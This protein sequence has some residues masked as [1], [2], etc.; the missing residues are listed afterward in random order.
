MADDIRVTF[1]AES[2]SYQS[3]LKKLIAQNKL[4]ETELKNLGSTFKEETSEEE[5]S[6][7]KK[8]ALNKQIKAQQEYVNALNAGMDKLTAEQKENTAEGLKQS[9]AISKAE[10]ALADMK[11]ELAEADK[12]TEE[13][14]EEVKD[15]G[16]NLEGFS[17]AAVM[18][19]SRELADFFN[20]AAG[21][22][23]EF[24]KK[25]LGGIIDTTKDFDSAM[26]QVSA[27]SGATGEEFDALRN[28]ARE[29]GASTKYSATESAEALNYMALAGWDTAEMTEGLDGVLNLA[30]ASG[31]DLAEASDIVTDYL[32]AFGKDASYAAKMADMMAYA[33]ANSNTTTR[34]LGEAF[35]NS[36]ATMNT[37]GQT[38]E[39]TTA[40]LE[41]MANQGNKGAEA[42][43][44]LSAMMRDLTQKMKDGKIMIGD[45]AVQVTDASGNF[46]N[47]IDILADVDA[48]TEGMGSAQK[49]AALMTTFT[50]RSVKGV[51]QLLTEGVGNLQ[52]YETALQG[53]SGAAGDMANTMQD[54]LEGQLTILKSSVQE[55][56]ISMGDQLT[57]YIRKAVEIIQGIIDKFNQLPD[58][59]KKAIAITMAVGTAFAVVAP[60]VM[61]LVNT[62]KSLQA[63]SAVLKSFKQAAD[64]A[65]GSGG[66]MVSSFG[67]TAGVV[68]TAAAAIAAFN[69]A[70]VEA[71][72]AGNELYQAAK[73]DIEA[74]S[75]LRTES[76]AYADKLEDRRAKEEAEA[77]QIGKLADELVELNGKSKLTTEEQARYQSIVTQLNNLL[78][79][80][81][82]EIDNST[83]KLKDQSKASKEA[84]DEL[85][86]NKRALT[87]TEDLTE[88]QNDLSEA[89]MRQR[90]ADEIATRWAD[91]FGTSLED[92]KAKTE[93]ASVGA[94]GLAAKLAQISGNALYTELITIAQAVVDAG[95]GSTEMAADVAAATDEVNRL[96]G[97][98]AE[99]TPAVDE[100]GNAVD[101]LGDEATE[102]ATETEAAAV[103]IEDSYSEILT[104]AQKD[105]AGSVSYI[106]EWATEGGAS[107]EGMVNTMKT[108]AAA[109]GNYTK[110]IQTLTSDMRYGTDLNYTSM[111]D[112]LIQQGPKGANAVQQLA[113][114]M[115]TGGSN[116][117][118]AMLT[119]YNGVTVQG[120]NLVNS[121]SRVQADSRMKLGAM[122]GEA[123]SALTNYVNTI[124]SYTGKTYSAGSSVADN[125]YS[126]MNSRSG[127]FKGIGSGEV[128][129]L[130]TGIES[131]E[132]ATEDSAGVIADATAKMQVDSA[133][134]IN[135]G[136]DLVHNFA[137][138]MRQAAWDVSDAV[139]E[140]VKP[141]NNK[142]KHSVPKEGVLH[143]E[144]EWGGHLVDNFIKGMTSSRS[145]SALN[146]AANKVAFAAMPAMTMPSATTTNN[147]LT[148][149]DIVVNVNGAGVKDEAALA[150]MVSNE[151]FRRVQAQKAVWS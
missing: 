67:K 82:G 92:L 51:S 145:L 30:A 7:A 115:Q 52:S 141:I 93:N 99:A 89:V 5:K 109:Y 87:A 144:P 18:A 2:S 136:A 24:G 110:N 35:G 64:G 27:L 69:S 38:M 46:R 96:S 66:N 149:G 43:T 143:T 54:N 42:G 20:Q 94:G 21:A 151:I 81:S 130:N 73:K 123:N 138:G 32:S 126:G 39:T 48:A 113:N 97:A 118:N 129:N 76:E 101:I 108:N 142:L 37:A 150:K 50:A 116:M 55:L 107:V 59:A 148:Y 44:A 119:A 121:I 84:I 112:M 8:A 57:P 9:T 23:A 128:S 132:G 106:D 10:A 63:A 40:L 70:M 26:S 127:E 105:L 135:W 111:V 80:F 134:S 95:Q 36:A 75:E 1:N 16:V 4:Y 34:Q 124:S 100:A 56:A 120:G 125:A 78:P 33:Q 25:A 122:S 104:A 85:T 53:A 31:M 29:M 72:L 14:G 86:N 19:A 3:E 146:A 22:A 71:T 140:V 91:T 103:S 11:K 90:E 74:L 88:A 45:T 47:M 62:F 13:F 68:A 133:Q 12:N 137:S 58:G 77:E 98:A 131:K 139:D 17:D 41:G 102:T 49:S 65:A 15:A 83:G 117:I 147:S 79:D 114:E 60:K 61:A 6:A 28:K